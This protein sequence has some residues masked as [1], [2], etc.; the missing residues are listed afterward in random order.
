MLTRMKIRVVS[1]KM[2]KNSLVLVCCN[3][4]EINLLMI[5]LNGTQ[6]S[7]FLV[8]TSC[9]WPHEILASYKFTGRW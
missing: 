4:S 8:T 5:T 7:V 2:M 6:V 9:I 3:Y 1:V